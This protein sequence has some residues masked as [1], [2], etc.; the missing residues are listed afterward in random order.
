[1]DIKII[2]GGYGRWHL[3]GI[4]D[5]V[6]TPKYHS[7]YHSNHRSFIE[8]YKDFKKILINPFFYLKS[9]TE[10][11]KILANRIIKDSSEA[12]LIESVARNEK[13]DYW[14]ITKERYSQITK[15]V[16]EKA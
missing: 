2:E 16:Y 14:K 15:M 12:I 3:E 10:L 11:Y 8:T 7:V 4:Y 5:N 9:D 1:M 6:Y 13:G